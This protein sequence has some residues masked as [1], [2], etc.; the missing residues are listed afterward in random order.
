MTS[1]LTRSLVLGLVA[2]AAT[3]ILGVLFVDPA[4]GVTVIGRATVV[5][6]NR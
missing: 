4:G 1:N 6:C 5:S 3:A 2:G